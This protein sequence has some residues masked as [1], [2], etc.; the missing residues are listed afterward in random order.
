MWQ[1]LVI[2]RTTQGNGLRG[3]LG[4]YGEV[5]PVSRAA[6]NSGMKEALE[7]LAERRNPA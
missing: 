6:L 5:M 1:Q 2:F 3:L 7:R 4:E